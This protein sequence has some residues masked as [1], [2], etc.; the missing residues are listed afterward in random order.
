MPF[1][2]ERLEAYQ[3]ALEFFDVADVVVE[4][5]RALG[6]RS[7]LADQLARAGLSVVNNIAEGTGGSWRCS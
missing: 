6:G 3:V 1:D 5:L 4:R 7:N 2:H